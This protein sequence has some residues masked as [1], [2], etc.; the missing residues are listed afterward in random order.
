M[1]DFLRIEVE[2]EQ[3]TKLARNLFSIRKVNKKHG[4]KVEYDGSVLTASELFISHKNVH[5]ENTLSTNK[6]ES[7]I[8]CKKFHSSENCE[9]AYMSLY[10]KKDAVKKQ[11]AC[12][13]C[14][15][16]NSHRAYQCRS[17]IKCLICK[18][19]HFIILCPDLMTKTNKSDNLENI[20]K[21]KKKTLA[22]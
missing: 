8:I 1:I 19:R 16:C 11:N 2:S 18:N 15:K 4:K 20:K 22:F 13:I 3:K 17:K 6:S 9:H 5:N 14:L 10:D 7:C 21:K 12:F